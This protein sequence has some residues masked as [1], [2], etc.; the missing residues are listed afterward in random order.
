MR[1]RA[2]TLGVK[3]FVSPYKK[4]IYFGKHILKFIVYYVTG[5]FLDLK[6]MHDFNT[7]TLGGGW[8]NLFLKL[9]LCICVC[10]GSG[11]WYANVSEST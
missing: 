4:T 3:I 10:V 2:R 9:C 5:T 1:S 8:G 6:T 11:E 7:S